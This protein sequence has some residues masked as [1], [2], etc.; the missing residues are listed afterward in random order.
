MAARPKDP[1]DSPAG[2]LQSFM[3]RFDPAYRKFIGSVRAALRKRLPTANELVYDYKTFIVIT[4]SPTDKPM[5]A[6]V[7][8]SARPDGLSLYFNNGPRLPDPKKLLQGSGKQVRFIAV[9][10]VSRLRH[11][12]VEALIA[13]AIDLAPLPLPATGRGQLI[14]RTDSEK[15]PTRR[16]PAK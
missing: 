9:E 14:I 15:M 2:R 3:E 10:T 13:A 4:Y 11:P 6:I 16:K 12:D 7:S 1:P 5:E 8:L